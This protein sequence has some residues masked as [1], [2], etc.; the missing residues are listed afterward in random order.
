[1]N[2]KLLCLLFAPSLIFAQTQSASQPAPIDEDRVRVIVGEQAMIIKTDL[3][4]LQKRQLELAQKEFELHAQ[5]V[6]KKLDNLFWL[7]ALLGSLLSAGILITI[8]QYARNYAKQKVK[9]EIDQVM[10]RINLELKLDLRQ[11]PIHIPRDNF[12]SERTRLQA[13]KYSK[14][15]PYSDLNSNLKEGL[16]IFRVKSDEDFKRLQKFMIDEHVDPL[17]C[18]FVIYYTEQPRLNTQLLSPFENFVIAN[19]PS[20]L[21]I[22][23]FL[24]SRNIIEDD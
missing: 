19:M 4:N 2:N 6:E 14:L 18:C 16:T 3:E 7:N 11:W 5:T 21:P 1:M 15:I 24:A 12:D 20:T 9:D 10:Q 22:Q 23:I 8:F 13:L 17:K